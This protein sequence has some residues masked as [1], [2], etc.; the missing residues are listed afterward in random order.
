M[1]FLYTRRLIDTDVFFMD[2]EMKLMVSGSYG[3]Q[4]I[5]RRDYRIKI[6]VFFEFAIILHVVKWIS[7]NN[8]S[9]ERFV[10]MHG[11]ISSLSNKINSF[12]QIFIISFV[13]IA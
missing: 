4:K 2:A 8:I 10:G 6:Y 13:K 5:S 9:S 12:V 7:D 3:I 1:V 11:M